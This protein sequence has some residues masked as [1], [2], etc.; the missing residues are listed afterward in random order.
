M[1]VATVIVFMF[2]CGLD[3]NVKG[4][5]TRAQRILSNAGVEVDKVKN[6]ATVKHTTHKQKVKRQLTF[7]A[8]VTVTS[9]PLHHG[10]VSLFSSIVW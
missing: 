2:C 7:E 6:L 4:F 5:L 3:V 10:V 1:E 9:C 8:G